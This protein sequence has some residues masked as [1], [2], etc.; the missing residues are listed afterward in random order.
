M[1]WNVWDY[2]QGQGLNTFFVAQ[3]IHHTCLCPHCVALHRRFPQ[4]PPWPD[5]VL[6][7]V[8]LLQT[9]AGEKAIQQMACRQFIKDLY[10]PATFTPRGWAAGFHSPYDLRGDAN[11]YDG[12][13]QPDRPHVTDLGAY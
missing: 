3:E 6:A 1:P 4:P 13:S 9:V 2:T 7:Q 8:L 11:A 12:D 10:D 5:L